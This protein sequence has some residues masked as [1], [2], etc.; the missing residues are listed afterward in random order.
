[1][2]VL[3]IAVAIYLLP[4]KGWLGVAAVTIWM[5]AVYRYFQQRHVI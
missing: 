4:L 1:M 2:P 3:I 5:L